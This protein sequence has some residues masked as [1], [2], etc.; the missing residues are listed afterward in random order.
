MDR[1][2]Q[3]GKALEEKV[4]SWQSPAGLRC[5]PLRWWSGRQN[6][7]GFRFWT[8]DRPAASRCSK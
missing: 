6:G 1:L 2:M 5:R 7:W 8:A 3:L 4:I